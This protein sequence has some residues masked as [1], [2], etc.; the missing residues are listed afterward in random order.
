VTTTTTGAP[1]PPAIT[2]DALSAPF[3]E[4]AKQRRLSLQRCQECGFYQHYPRPVCRRCSSFQLGFEQVSGRGT[5]YSFTE[6]RKAFHPFFADRVPYLLASIEL[7]EQAGLRIV[8]NL[9]KIAEPEVAFGMPVAVEFEELSADLTIPVFA[10]A[11]A[12]A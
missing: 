12:A 7:V 8:S 9:V 3:W 4:A 6:T 11:Q 1:S 5:V 2:V 10:P